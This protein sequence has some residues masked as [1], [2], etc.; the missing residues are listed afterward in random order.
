MK[1]ITVLLLFLLFSGIILAQSTKIGIRVGGN[2]S[3]QKI[4]NEGFDFFNIDYDT[5][6]LIGW[7][8]GLFINS[9]INDAISIQPELLIARKGYQYDDNGIEVT[10]DPLYI[11]LPVPILVNLNVSELDFF[12]GA[13]PYLSYGIGGEGEFE[14]SLGD[15]D[16]VTNGDI[17]WGD[18]SDDTYRPFDAGAV[19]TAGFNVTEKVQVN[20][21]YELGLRNI[22]AN[23]DSDNEVRNRSFLVNLGYFI[24]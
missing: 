6:S 15:F 19:F 7:Q 20:V 16:L 17:E 8:A 13:G 24:N 10:V 2:L 5:E 4:E 11:H 12:I 1:K 9:S 18:D 14:G 21:S 3:N 23:G 22:Q